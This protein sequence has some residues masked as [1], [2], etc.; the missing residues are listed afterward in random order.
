V[1][2]ILQDR[3]LLPST[4]LCYI[5]ELH[6]YIF[7]MLSGHPQAI[8]MYKIKI[9]IATS[10]MGGRIEILIFGVTMYMLI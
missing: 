4:E 8:K 6:A 10:V 5:D 1:L 9:T 7:R 3:Y 2:Y